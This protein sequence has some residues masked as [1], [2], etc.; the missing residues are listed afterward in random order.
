MQIELLCAAV[1]ASIQSTRPDSASSAAKLE[2]PALTQSTKCPQ[3]QH[4]N[5]T[6]K[7]TMEPNAAKATYMPPRRKRKTICVWWLKKATNSAPPFGDNCIIHLIVVATNSAQRSGKVALQQQVFLS[8]ICFNPSS[9]RP[10]SPTN[11]QTQIMAR[12]NVSNCMM[13]SL[14]NRIVQF[15]KDANRC[16][17]Q[18]ATSVPNSNCEQ[19]RH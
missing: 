8:Q 14:L 12:S 16:L 9:L 13:T 4:C 10:P 2:S 15:A 3:M 5:Q 19:N 11:Q 6:T 1:A 18:L 17:L 7:P